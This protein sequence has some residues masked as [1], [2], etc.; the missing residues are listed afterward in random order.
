[1]MEITD[2]KHRF[3]SII[4]IKGKFVKDFDV[5]SKHTKKVMFWEQFNDSDKDFYCGG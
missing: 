1:M 5:F 4:S 3:G 2:F